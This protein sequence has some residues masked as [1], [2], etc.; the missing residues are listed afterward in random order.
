MLPLTPFNLEPDD[1]PIKRILGTI[2]GY[3]L[4]DA[5]R[6]IHIEVPSAQQGFRIFYRLRENDELRQQMKLPFYAFKPLRDHLE[7]LVGENGSFE[8]DLAS[9]KH[10]ISLTYVVEMSVQKAPDGETIILKLKGRCNSL[11]SDSFD[12]MIQ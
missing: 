9:E 5:A 3:A 4:T 10:Q 11:S 6:G 12:D 1:A 2:V 8:V 7:L